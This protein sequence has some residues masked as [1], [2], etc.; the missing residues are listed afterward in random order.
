MDAEKTFLIVMR[1]TTLRT[2]RT[3]L[4]SE[5]AD[6]LHGVVATL[7]R[8]LKTGRPDLFRDIDRPDKEVQ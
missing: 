6:L 5:D 1:G 3:V 8:Q 7:T 2:A 4:V